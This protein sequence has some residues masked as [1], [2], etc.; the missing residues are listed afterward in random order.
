MVD[1]IDMNIQEQRS[2]WPVENQIEFSRLDPH[3]CEV[4]QSL[5]FGKRSLLKFEP[6]R[7]GIALNISILFH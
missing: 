1:S 7:E 4:M 6:D 5:S 2:T 3:L